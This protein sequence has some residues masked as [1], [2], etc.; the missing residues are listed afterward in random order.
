MR[1]SKVTFIG[2]LMAVMASLLI[3]LP[4]MAADGTKSISVSSAT[5]TLKVYDEGDVA[6]SAVEVDD[7]T[8]T[9][10]A[11][12]TRVGNDL[13]ASNDPDAFNAVLVTL[14]DASIT[15]ATTT[16]DVEND[17]TGVDLV[18]G[19]TAASKLVLNEGV[20]GLFQG[21]FYIRKTASASTDYVLADDGEVV[22]VTK[23]SLS[24]DIVVDGDGPE[25]ASV[26]PTHETIQKTSGATFSANVTDTGSG[27][28]DDAANG[29]SGTGDTAKSGE[30]LAGSDGAS[31]DIDIN[32]GMA[33]A[34]AD[35][36]SADNA[37]SLATSGWTEIDDGFSFAFSYPNVDN[38]AV[39]GAV[40][41]NVVSRDR[42]GNESTTDVDD[43]DDSADHY[44]LSIDD[45][46]PKL[47]AAETGTGWDA[48]D[49]EEEDNDA[50]IKLTFLNG[51]AG[52][53]EDIDADTVSTSD[54]VLPAGLTADSVI[55][56]DNAIYIILTADLAPDDEPN[57]QMLAGAI[58]DTAGN[59]NGTESIDATDKIEPTFTVTAAGQAGTGR[60]VT[61]GDEDDGEVTITVSSNEELDAAPTLS[62]FTMDAAS[63]ALDTPLVKT[64]TALTLKATDNDN[65]WSVTTDVATDGLRGIHV[66]GEDDNNSNDG[67]SDGVATTGVTIAADDVVT[68][69]DLASDG[70]LFEVD[71]AISQAPTVTLLP[72]V[73]GASTDTESTT[74]SIRIVY[75]EGAEY[76]ISATVGSTDT[77]DS[78][79]ETIKTEDIKTEI[80]SFDTVTITAAALS[81]SGLTADIDVLGNVRVL[82]DATFSIVLSG[83]DVDG[84]GDTDA[85]DVLPLDEYTLT[86]TAEDAVGNENE[87]EEYDFEIVERSEYEVE[88]ELGWNLISLPGTPVDATLAGIFGT[89]HDIQTVTTYQ[90]GAF[91]SAAYDD[92]AWVGELTEM[93]AGL[94]YWVESKEFGTFETLLAEVSTTTELPTASVHAG[95]NLLGVI[96]LAQNDQNDA[97]STGDEADDYFTFDWVIAY[98]FDTVRGFIPIQPEKDSD[99]DGDGTT[100]ADDKE[101]VNG[102]GFWVWSDEKS[103]LLPLGGI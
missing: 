48:D 74:P 20:G 45:T 80:D 100:D 89:D 12:D 26:A 13:Y 18:E 46:D 76:T 14:S 64:I 79:T 98:M 50:A 56:E 24:V 29:D 16:V 19:T 72:A 47:T 68:L 59:S 57:I 38:Q 31:T 51:A 60:P 23:G 21:L 52:S 4:A 32:V 8:V 93:T 33:S 66:S 37:S 67:E 22:N 87:D 53:A 5:L 49:E 95:W 69:A 84:D 42:V 81:S 1:F 10:D 44:L 90:D 35:A 39:S 34:T 70:L 6:T 71:T 7:A 73:T 83:L 58:D 61:F 101:I 85:A 94:G 92:G 54:F 9:T 15:T 11:R 75:A 103:T 17:T 40:N 88:L 97:P 27:L 77:G 86:W 99:I 3:L 78:V 63:T 91:V 43:D 2:T 65:E 96:D 25:V 62:I 102:R 30:P 55:V 82:D 28:R 41:W 36:V